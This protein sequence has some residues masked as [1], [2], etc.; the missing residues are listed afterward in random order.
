VCVC[1]CV[2]YTFSKK[3]EEFYTEK[4][5]FFPHLFLSHQE[6]SSFSLFTVPIPISLCLSLSRPEL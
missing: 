6:L 4:K 5:V 1:V 2:R 3:K